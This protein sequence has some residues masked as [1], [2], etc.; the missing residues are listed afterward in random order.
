MRYTGTMLERDARSGKKIGGGTFAPYKVSYI[1]WL[2]KLGLVTG[3][4]WLVLHGDMFA[5]MESVVTKKQATIGWLRRGSKETMK[6]NVHQHGS[7]KRNIA[8]RPFV[9]WRK[10]YITYIT[11]NIFWPWMERN[12]KDAGLNLTFRA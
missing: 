6:A 7:N 4:K 11:D 3:K 9:G 12:A 5:A 8:A 2:Q 1:E 10:N